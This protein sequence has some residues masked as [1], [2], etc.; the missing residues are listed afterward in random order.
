MTPQEAAEHQSDNPLFVCT[1]C[2]EPV[3]VYGGQYF[4][5]CEHEGAPFAITLQGLKEIARGIS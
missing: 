1:C 4:R 3:I 5:T 2:G